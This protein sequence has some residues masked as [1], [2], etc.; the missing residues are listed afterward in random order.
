MARGRKERVEKRDN[1]RNFFPPFQS[2]SLIRQVAAFLASLFKFFHRFS[3]LFLRGVYPF[4]LDYYGGNRFTFGAALLLINSPDHR[5]GPFFL[6]G[7]GVPFLFLSFASNL[8]CGPL[9]RRLPWSRLDGIVWA[10]AG[11]S[12]SLVLNPDLML[13]TCRNETETQCSSMGQMI[14]WL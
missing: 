10:P 11:Y 4:D 3:L 8:C 5:F 14:E 7:C 2:L 6:T 1:E 9:E 12:L 13:S